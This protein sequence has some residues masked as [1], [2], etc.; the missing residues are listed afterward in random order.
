MCCTESERDG[1]REVAVSPRGVSPSV[2]ICLCLGF[3]GI[4]VKDEPCP[5]TI[6]TARYF[7]SLPTVD[8]NNE[9]R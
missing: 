7:P 2:G 8:N 6:T 5:R 9:G 4:A 3:A 1:G